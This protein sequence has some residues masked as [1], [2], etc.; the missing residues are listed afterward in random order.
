[1]ALS[2]SKKRRPEVSRLGPMLLASLFLTG[3]VS[4]KGADGTRHM[5][6][7]G[8][9][10]IS[11][12]EKTAS[13]ATVTDTCFFGLG[14]RTGGPNRGIVVG[15]QSSH[16]TNIPPDWSG[17]FQTRAVLSKPAWEQIQRP[18]LSSAAT[19][20]ASPQN[21]TANPSAPHQ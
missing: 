8:I 2:S 15:Y 4:W 16:E 3:C 7:V 14:A 6:V 18:L 1:M 5:L 17:A 10:V 20:S 21:P 11:Q 19:S 12:S 9:G 13:N